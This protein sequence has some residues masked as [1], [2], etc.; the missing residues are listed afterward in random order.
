MDNTIEESLKNAQRK[1]D[2]QKAM[3]Q[4]LSEFNGIRL[5]YIFTLSLTEYPFLGLESIEGWY[6]YINLNINMFTQFFKCNTSD[7]FVDVEKLNT[8]QFLL[9]EIIRPRTHLNKYRCSFENVNFD[10]CTNGRVFEVILDPHNKELKLNFSRNDLSRL[11]HFFK[12]WCGE[13][14]V[15]SLDLTKYI[16]KDAYVSPIYD[17]PYESI[18]ELEYN[19]FV[20]YTYPDDVK[21]AEIQKLLE[22]NYFSL[23]DK[24]SDSLLVTY[25]ANIRDRT[26]SRPPFQDYSVHIKGHVPKNYSDETKQFVRMMYHHMNYWSMVSVI[27]SFMGTISL[28]QEFEVYSLNVSVK[29]RDSFKRLL[30]GREEAHTQVETLRNIKKRSHHF[31]KFAINYNC[32]GLEKD[33]SETYIMGNIAGEYFNLFKKTSTPII[34]K[35]LDNGDKTEYDDLTNDYDEIIE[36]LEKRM[37]DV[38]E[39]TRYLETKYYQDYQ[40]KYIE[41]TQ[42]LTILSIMSGILIFLISKIPF[43]AINLVNLINLIKISHYLYNFFFIS[44]FKSII[45]IMLKLVYILFF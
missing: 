25:G 6:K 16:D 22:N 4:E 35:F 20:V 12:R 33:V 9:D 31:L 38:I 45:S 41:T 11:S 7:Y 19:S 30:F 21:T 43:D 10:V 1:C 14:L 39:K 28:F 5:H 17:S 13:I 34:T 29:K 42:E 23:K 36:E 32:R 3:E 18:L 8:E 44:V 40:I 26:R 24:I 15:E 2:E 27:D 37:N